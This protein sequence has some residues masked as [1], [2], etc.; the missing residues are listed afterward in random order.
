MY[1]YRTGG[2]PSWAITCANLMGDRVVSEASVCLLPVSLLFARKFL[3]CCLQ[4]LGDLPCP[5]LQQR[6]L[7]VTALGSN[8]VQA[9]LSP[10]SD[11]PPLLKCFNNHDTTRATRP[12]CDITTHDTTHP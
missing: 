1:D 8:R 12:N 3:G 7:V 10:H 4:S 6:P 11:R 2:L 9:W 5:Y